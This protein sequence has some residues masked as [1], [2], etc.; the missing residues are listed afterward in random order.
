MC[1]FSIRMSSSLL[2]CLILMVTSVVKNPTMIRVTLLCGRVLSGRA[3]RR[4]LC[5][6]PVGPKDLHERHSCATVCKTRCSAIIKAQKVHF[7]EKHLSSKSVFSLGVPP[8]DSVSIEKGK[9]V[10]QKSFSESPFTPD[11]VSLC[12]PKGTTVDN[13]DACVNEISYMNSCKRTER[14][15]LRLESC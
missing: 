2:K 3:L 7:F 12:A 4:L 5:S 11:R 13:T 9:F 15:R 14:E 10:F 6:G 8:R 1:F